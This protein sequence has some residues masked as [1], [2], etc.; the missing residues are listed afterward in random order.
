[1]T[2]PKDDTFN[3]FQEAM[4]GV[5]QIKQDKISPERQRIK[6]KHTQA[7]QQKQRRA[8]IDQTSF[9][10]SDEYHPHLP[11]EGPM[12]WHSDQCDPF[13]LKKLRRGDYPPEI[14]LDLHGL[15]QQQAKL[16]IA[17]L[18]VECQQQHYQVASIMHG[19]GQRILQS[20]VPR[21]L[22]QHPE[23]L[24]FHQ[25]PKEHGGNSALLVLLPLKE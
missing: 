17:A 24:A 18:L 8:K 11:S 10:F 19:H 7:Q 2:D 20:A 3:S 13:E 23:V 1:M 16:E 21:W 22:A 4:Q 5:R 9:F 12:R 25:A 14:F 6:Q 15:T